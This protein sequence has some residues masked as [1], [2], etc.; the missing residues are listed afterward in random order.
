LVSSDLFV[1]EICDLAAWAAVDWSLEE[2][3]YAV[4]ADGVDEGFAVGGDG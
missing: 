2:I 1:G 3:F 4:Y